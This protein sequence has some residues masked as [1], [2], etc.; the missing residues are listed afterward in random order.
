MKIIKAIIGHNFLTLISECRKNQDIIKEGGSRLLQKSTPTLESYFSKPVFMQSIP[1]PIS[2]GLLCLVFIIIYVS[3]IAG[4]LDQFDLSPPVY[5]SFF[6]SALTIVAIFLASIP[7]AIGRGKK[8]GVNATMTIYLLGL[9]ITLTSISL[10]LAGYLTTIDFGSK[11][12]LIP[13]QVIT[14]YLAR[15][16][17]NSYSFHKLISYFQIKKLVL[18]AYKIKERMKTINH[19]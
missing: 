14:T 3:G 9:T 4:I 19:L 12:K 18:E 2:V 10:T 13:I 6:F 1:N 8:W 15:C 11:I 7:F 5:V 16:I 17:I